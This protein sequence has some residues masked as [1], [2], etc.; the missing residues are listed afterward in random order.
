[1]KLDWKDRLHYKTN[2]YDFLEKEDKK[3]VTAF[4]CRGGINMDRIFAEIFDSVI[5]SG[6]GINEVL[7]IRVHFLNS[8]LLEIFWV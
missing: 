6:G 4:K 5:G 1:M 3:S 7:Q 8:T 2:V